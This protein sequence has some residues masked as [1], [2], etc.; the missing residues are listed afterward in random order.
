MKK[1]IYVP[2]EAIINESTLWKRENKEFVHKVNNLVYDFIT[3]HNMVSFFMR[4]VGSLSCLNDLKNYK[5]LNYNYVGIIFDSDKPLAKE[6]ICDLGSFPYDTD[7]VT[8]LN[9]RDYK[10]VYAQYRDIN[11]IKNNIGDMCDCSEVNQAMIKDFFE[12]I[13]KLESELDIYTGIDSTME[14]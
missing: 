10:D 3:S 13:K 4:A 9:Y 8:R 6:W 2:I 11:R 14:E 7:E 12:T 5:Y 1:A